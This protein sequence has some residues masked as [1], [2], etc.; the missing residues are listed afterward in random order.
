MAVPSIDISFLFIFSM[1]C[2]KKWLLVI[3]GSTDYILSYFLKKKFE[4]KDVMTSLIKNLKAPYSVNS[5]H[6]CCH[7]ARKNGTF[8]WLCKQEGMGV[9]FE[10][11]VPGTLQQNKQVK[12]L[13]LYLNR[14][15]ILNDRKF[16]PCWEMGCLLR[17]IILLWYWKIIIEQF[18]RKEKRNILT[19]LEKLGKCIVFYKGLSLLRFIIDISRWQLRMASKVWSECWGW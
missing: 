18:F 16:S 7:N 19:S 13:P 4:L 15:M 11:M 14:C 3:K 6:I 1:D 17:Q 9:K 5:W 2:V 12:K 10:N 8:E